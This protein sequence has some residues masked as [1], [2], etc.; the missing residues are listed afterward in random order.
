MVQI[1]ETRRIY[2]EVP[3][4]GGTSCCGSRLRPEVLSS[5]GLPRPLDLALA[6][7]HQLD[8]SLLCLVYHYDDLWTAL[9]YALYIIVTI[10]D[11]LHLLCLRRTLRTR[12]HRHARRGSAGQGGP[13]VPERGV[14]WGDGGRKALRGGGRDGSLVSGWCSAAVSSPVE[15]SGCRFTR[16]SRMM[17]RPSPAAA[18]PNDA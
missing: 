12:T 7:G 8:G 4:P 2:Q 1:M 5:A 14:R 13:W 9:T 10:C 17:P 15:S 18:Q 11:L 16:L 6:S 3:L